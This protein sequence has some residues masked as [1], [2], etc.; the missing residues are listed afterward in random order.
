[1]QNIFKM[2]RYNIITQEEKVL[3]TY[4]EPN[5]QAEEFSVNKIMCVIF[6]KD[7]FSNQVNNTN[8]LYLQEE[9]E[10]CNK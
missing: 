3:R 8:E 7:S 5:V 2:Y 9:K 6:Q 4:A 1:M 10:F